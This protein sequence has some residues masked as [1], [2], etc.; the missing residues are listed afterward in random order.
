MQPGGVVE[1]EVADK[2]LQTETAPGSACR[3]D[4]LTKG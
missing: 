3:D 2:E 4:G 1:K